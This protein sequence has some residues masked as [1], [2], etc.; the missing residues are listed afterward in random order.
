MHKISIQIQRSESKPL[1]TH[2]RLLYSKHAQKQLNYRQ[3]KKI[4]IVSLNIQII[5]CAIRQ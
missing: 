2:M 4:I 3:A 5:T 1:K